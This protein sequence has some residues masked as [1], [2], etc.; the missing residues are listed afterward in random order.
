MLTYICY[1]SLGDTSELW[2]CVPT[3]WI[4]ISLIILY[5]PSFAVINLAS[6][7]TGIKTVG[8]APLV[9][10]GRS[11]LRP[12]YEDNRNIEWLLVLSPLRL[13]VFPLFDLRGLSPVVSTTY[14]GLVDV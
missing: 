3:I 9:S 13:A 8:L 6:L 14:V 11:P 12:L 10:Y 2:Y 7:W 4:W 1:W 5:P